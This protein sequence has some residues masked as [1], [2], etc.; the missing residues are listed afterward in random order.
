MARATRPRRARGEFDSG[1]GRETWCPYRAAQG[2]EDV[3]PR[4][5]LHRVRPD[6]PHADCPGIQGHMGR[7]EHLIQ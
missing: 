3:R 1:F 5:F 4:E 2:I 6:R 7:A